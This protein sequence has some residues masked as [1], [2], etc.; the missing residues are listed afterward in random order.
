MYIVVR[1]MKAQKKDNAEDPEVEKKPF[2]GEYKI[3][4]GDTIK[5]GRLKFSVKDFRT[6][7]HSA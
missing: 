1:N 7:S 6:D 2:S 3:G 5:M 4:K